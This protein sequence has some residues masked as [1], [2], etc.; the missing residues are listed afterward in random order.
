[1]SKLMIL[2]TLAMFWGFFEMSGGTNFE[3]M[4]REAAAKAPFAPAEPEVAQIQEPAPVTNVVNASFEV[5]S[6]E[7]EVVNAVV[8][9]ISL[10]V[11]AE[12]VAPTA[13]TPITMHLVDGDWVNMR[14]GPST[15]SAVLD[16]LPRGTQAE[17]IDVNADGWAQVRLVSNGQVG[18]MAERLLTES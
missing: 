16:T 1:M 4:Q 18:W 15:T 9:Q 2:C 10:V 17:I 11:P 8:E 7:P 14:D 6:A 13:Q 12:P 5:P 3:P